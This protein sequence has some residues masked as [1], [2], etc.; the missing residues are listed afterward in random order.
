MLNFFERHCLS[1]SKRVIALCLC[2]V[3]IITAFAGIMIFNANA[4]QVEYYTYINNYYPLKG[5]YSNPEFYKESDWSFEGRN[6]M[7]TADFETT[8][9]GFEAP[10][11]ISSDDGLSANIEWKSIVN[12]DK[13]RVDVFDGTQRLD[14]SCKIAHS[15]YDIIDGLDSMH[16]Y[17]VQIVALDEH[18]IVIAA[19]KVR[20]FITYK[21]ASNEDVML[22]GTSTNNIWGITLAKYPTEADSA[23]S[24]F[25]GTN[26]WQASTLGTFKLPERVEA[27]AFWFGQTNSDGSEDNWIFPDFRLSWSYQGANGTVNSTFSGT[28]VKVYFFSD[29]GEVYTNLRGKDGYNLWHSSDTKKF[30]QGLV[31]I[32]V[33]IYKN[34]ASISGKDVSFT[35]ALESVRR[36]KQSSPNSQ[37]IHTGN[38]FN[39]QTVYYDDFRT[40][41]DLN[42]FLSSLEDVSYNAFDNPIYQCDKVDTNTKTFTNTD[43]GSKYS[44]IFDGD[45]GI[46]YNLKD[47]GTGLY[48]M[49]LKFTAPKSSGYDVSNYIKVINNNIAASV[50][51]RVLKEDTSG[52]ETQ[53]WPINNWYQ[54]NADSSNYNP[55]SPLELQNVYLKKGEKLR[56]EA[57]ADVLSE[58]GGE[59][60]VKF[61]NTYLVPTETFE[62]S[63]GTVTVYP[64]INYM[65]CFHTTGSI[66]G[67]KYLAGASRWNFSAMNLDDYSAVPLT[68]YAEFWGR[69]TYRDM[70]GGI[71]GVYTD[72]YD[73]DIT[74]KTQTNSKNGVRMD[75]TSTQSGIAVISMKNEPTGGS[76]PANLRILLN[77][78]QIYPIGSAWTQDTA[79]F[80]VSCDV[81]NGD[82]ISI[83][84]YCNQGNT[85]N[86]V[87][88][89]SV[90]TGNTSNL[91]GTNYY[92]A[93]RERPWQGKSY[94]GK[95]DQ[96]DNIW[97]FDIY[98]NGT[99]AGD[100]FSYDDG[101]IVYNSEIGKSDGYRFTEKEILF[102]ISEK[103]RG[104]SLAFKV[105]I[106]GFYD[107][108]YALK[109]LE[110]NG[111]ISYRIRNGNTGLYPA[112]GWNTM[113]LESNLSENHELKLIAGE[114]LVLDVFAKEL[115]SPIKLSL[116]NPTIVY[117]NEF[118][119][120]E[121][122][123]CAV[124]NAF[125]Y[126]NHEKNYSGMVLLDNKRF[127]YELTNGSSTESVGFADS[128]TG[129]FGTSNDLS[130]GFLVADNSIKMLLP[131]SETG[132][133]IFTSPRKGYSNILAHAVSADGGEFTVTVIKNNEQIYN[134]T[135]NEHQIDLY[136]ALSLGD[137]ITITA[138]GN[139][140]IIWNSLGISVDGV[141]DNEN[142][143][144]ASVFTA[145]LVLPY[146]DDKYVGKYKASQKIW[147]FKTY[148]PNKDK[149]KNVDYYD[150]NNDKHLYEKASGVGYYF[151]NK[152]L[153][154]DLK[155]TDSE[156][157]GISLE[158]VA[159]YEEIFEFSSGLQIDTPNNANADIYV[160]IT[161]NGKVVWPLKGDYHKIEAAKTGQDIIIPMQYLE[162]KKGDCVALQIYGDN[163]T[164]SDDSLKISLAAP[165]LK[166][167]DVIQ[168]NTDFTA[169]VYSAGKQRPF[170]GID[171]SGKYYHTESMWNFEFLDFSPNGQ[172]TDE[173]VTLLGDN[174]SINNIECNMGDI[175]PYYQI[176]DNDTVL[177]SYAVV[178]D[179]GKRVQTS[180]Q[181]IRFVSPI[182]G[183]VKLFGTPV[184]SSLSEGQKAYFRVIQNG[185]TVFPTNGDWEQLD[186]DNNK[187][188]MCEF[189]LD[190]EVDDEICYQFY[191][192]A[193]DTVIL[194][195]PNKCATA[196]FRLNP[197]VVYYDYISTT[198]TS[199]NFLNDITRGIQLNPFWK[200]EYSMSR[201]NIEWTQLERYHDSWN[202]W[203][204]SNESMGTSTAYG[205]VWIKNGFNKEV[206]PIISA[207]YT[208]H[209]TGFIKINEMIF[210]VSNN[211]PRFPAEVRITLNDEKVWPV[212]D[213]WALVDLDNIPII[214]D[215]KFPITEGD[216][217]RFEVSPAEPMAV[218]A[219]DLRI[220]I[221]PQFTYSKYDEVYS[222]DKDIFGML[223]P[224]T[225]SY[226]KGLEA[227]QFDINPNETMAQSS[228][229]LASLA[230]RKKW[231]DEKITSFLNMGESNKDT[232]T[233][234]VKPGTPDQ[235]IPGTDT[236]VIKRR[237]KVVV[238]YTGGLPVWGIVLIVVGS[239]LVVGTTVFFVVF[240]R[241]KKKRKANGE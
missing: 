86:G 84:Q 172:S 204:N 78:K 136:S 185:E 104:F 68:D 138:S 110:G 25:C 9:D 234:I 120:N 188:A 149:T 147:N 124:Y 150:S 130:K 29:D 193:Q 61:V 85:M 79:Q 105:P 59:V 100:S 88:T 7:E 159:P 39:N 163:F 57:Y 139:K 90:Y 217:I 94:N 76:S 239:V 143:A 231:W 229:F 82:I 148:Y 222:K 51:Y 24:L 14:A 213:E 55:S 202:I 199:F 112:S 66:S 50:Y 155:Q 233:V 135:S 87:P 164:T 220:D 109:L 176:G 17:S 181:S 221:L 36:Y 115:S 53:V 228:S 175:S 2:F 125:T 237:K 23:L 177:T 30:K 121:S 161:N 214:S 216:K 49:S 132:K 173:P 165:R 54:M 179:L 69:M 169:M 38:N 48:G 111:E 21:A 91:A 226:F 41:S 170:I 56:F 72:I 42:M 11:V 211:V 133:I 212:E 8:T 10:N 206:Q 103:D 141:Y 134:K 64:S 12:A 97:S 47:T 1:L 62:T 15:T 166:V 83:Q 33:G 93:L 60:N 95:W 89:V 102:D 203:L 20:E 40:I 107:V 75:F 183:T 44:Y 65:D 127:V 116:G 63:K 208:A 70:S 81:E 162:L 19:S 191:T 71:V 101:G 154:A 106:T 18:D 67:G 241:K 198:K 96:S 26:P 73:K 240:I 22:D 119:L 215:L 168:G 46:S 225:Y 182:S 160:R 98:S 227:K 205:Q 34:G 153:Y 16:R 195:M 157:V 137:V 238:T 196:T 189:E 180:G 13:Y 167:H 200:A 187:S 174:F 32:P 31:V 45:Q 37:I 113:N 192:D 223:D 4:D 128:Q 126:L 230:L 201:D 28:D 52:I 58:S 144:S 158:F 207:T 77:D 197:A 35:L 27:I 114:E 151:K 236:K 142:D 171:Y 123:K 140:E 43:F 218:D 232:T 210:Q 118:A 131:N 178:D 219:E 190:I 80:S 152:L 146:G 145:S 194:N 6:F 99:K 129:L 108:G 156:T 92:S 5:G 74:L 209:A 3:I 184:V 122:G 235:Y 224:N 186:S 117:N